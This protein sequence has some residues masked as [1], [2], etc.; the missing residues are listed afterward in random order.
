[1]PSQRTE[2]AV[3][4]SR[5]ASIPPPLPSQRTE[6]STPPPDVALS[7]PADTESDAGEEVEIDEVEL[8][9]EVPPEPSPS[10]REAA[11]KGLIEI[12]PVVIAPV[13]LAAE[14]VGEFIG[15]VQ[16]TTPATFGDILDGTLDLRFED[17]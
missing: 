12:A 15:E 3:P 10:L 14:N 1:L 13:R 7:A 5:P 17:E 2:D 4:S 6:Q 11:K 8:L 9:T 16:T